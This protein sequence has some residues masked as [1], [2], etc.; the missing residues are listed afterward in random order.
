MSVTVN[1]VTRNLLLGRFLFRCFCGLGFS[2]GGFSR[3][4]SSVGVQ[5]VCG[6]LDAPLQDDS[7]TTDHTFLIRSV[8]VVRQTYDRCSR[9]PRVVR[10]TFRR[11]IQPQVDTRQVHHARG[12]PRYKTNRPKRCPNG[13]W[14]E[15]HTLNFISRLQHGVSS[16][17]VNMALIIFCS[18]STGRC[19]SRQ[20]KHLSSKTCV[21]NVKCLQ[22]TTS[23]THRASG[24]T[25]RPPPVG[26]PSAGH[27]GGD[28]VEPHCGAATRC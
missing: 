27:Q 25:A 8:T 6:A 17:L 5:E 19:F 26:A 21:G 18:N 1:L 14:R 3:D 11:K 2:G 10:H 23:R 9:R 24:P 15:A 16:R 4:S 7:A 13:H 28:H 12:V 22:P 20:A